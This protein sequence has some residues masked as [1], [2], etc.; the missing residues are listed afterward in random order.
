MSGPAI[1]HIIAKEVI[2]ELQKRLD[3][4]YHPFLDS[5][6]NEHAAAFLLGSQ[7]P[8][9]LFFNTKDID[10]TLKRFIDLYLDVIDFI[11]EV[12]KQILAIIPQQLK[13]AVEHLEAIY[14][15]LEERSSTLTEISELLTEAKNLI[16]LLT[17]TITAKLEQFLTDNIEIFEL[18]ENPVQDGHSFDEWWWFDTLHYRRTGSFTQAL[19]QDSVPGSIEHAYALG[20]LTHYA[21]DVVGHPFV[22]IISGG[23]YRT[24]PKRHKL[25]ENHHDVKSFMEY[26]GGEE[27]IQ[28]RLGEEYIIDGDEKHLPG[29]LNNFILRAIRRVYFDESGNSLYG[30]E[31]SS[32]DLNDAYRLWL[33]WFRKTTNSLDL[34]KPE[35]YSFS[36]E[37]EEVWDTFV[38][39][40]GDI[41]DSIADGFSGDGGILGILKAIAMA[42]LAPLLGA[43]ALV[44]AI[45]GA[46]TTLAAAPIRVLI[47][48]VYEKLY[49][50]YMNLHQAIVLNGF[51]FPFNSMLPHYLLSHLYDSGV[52]DTL[53]T[54]ADDLKYLFPTKK[55]KPSGMECESHLIYPT[56]V[57]ANSEPDSC[58]GAS[59]S[60]YHA[61]FST[62]IFGKIDFSRSGYERLKEF[63]EKKSGD[64]PEVTESKFSE[65]LETSSADVFG[66]AI[67]FSC[68]LYQD[69]LEGLKLADFNFDADRGIG[70]KAWRKVAD[71]DHVNDATKPHVAVNTDNTVLNMHTDIIDPSEEII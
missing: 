40:L 58:R 35:P 23:P 50:A 13:D 34:P 46:I 28:S 22:N 64:T 69:F 44:D 55:F 14:D 53:G 71:Y 67:E 37:I 12:K 47:S 52:D 49:D 39:N 11:E 60:Y 51:G 36:D 62:Y 2:S 10:P 17:T 20:Y 31:M 7:G 30:S 25:V 32:D 61:D 27:F 6:K 9:F 29:G 68:V 4:S 8:D 15:D 26:S 5:L 66:S 33:L 42:I 24:H 70:F 21:G 1:H 56:P 38:D 48:I 65:L 59:K 54:S 57:S 43:A 63:V 45:L 3:P 16:E 18:L 19:L 41:G